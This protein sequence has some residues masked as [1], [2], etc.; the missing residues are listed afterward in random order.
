MRRDKGIGCAGSYLIVPISLQ[1]RLRNTPFR[2]GGNLIIPGTGELD[3]GL[4]AGG[5]IPSLFGRMFHSS[6]QR[7]GPYRSTKKVVMSVPKG[8][9]LEGLN[10]YSGRSD[11][12]ALEDAEYPEWLP[13]LLDR[14]KISL[15][16]P[17]DERF[18]M[19]YFKHYRRVEKA[20]NC[21]RR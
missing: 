1:L 2:T 13:T 11:P 10:I 12:V 3:N 17:I 15:D 5:S 14:P 19:E 4:L 20:K 8:T 18:S 7:K 16:I 6:L 9:V 21:S